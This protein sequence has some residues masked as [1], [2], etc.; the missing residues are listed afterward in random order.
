MLSSSHQAL[1]RLSEPRSAEDDAVG[2]Y[3]NSQEVAPLANQDS[4]DS[5]DVED[6]YDDASELLLQEPVAGKTVAEHQ[7]PAHGRLV[8][9]YYIC[10]IILLPFVLKMET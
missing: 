6:D 7:P 1:P 2:A 9:N 4:S 8:C 5:A 3:L 10:S